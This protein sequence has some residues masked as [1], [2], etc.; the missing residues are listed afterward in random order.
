MTVP[1]RGEDMLLQAIPT[2]P[3]FSPEQIAKA[4]LAVCDRSETSEEAA[5]FLAMLGLLEGTAS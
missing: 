3:R 1:R 2:V 5:M 4:Q